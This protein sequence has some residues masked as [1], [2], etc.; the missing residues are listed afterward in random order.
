MFNEQ[1]KAVGIDSFRELFDNKFT[2]RDLKQAGYTLTGE[3]QDAV[4]YGAAVLGPKIGNGFY[5]NM[6][7]RFDQLTVDRWVRRT[8]GRWTGTL[9]DERPDMVAKK[10]KAMRE[11]IIKMSAAEKANF[12]EVGVTIKSRSN[13]DIE[14]TAQKIL[15][16]SMKPANRTVMNRTD[17]GGDLRKAGNGLAKYLDG[18]I[19]SPSD[20]ERDRIRRVFNSGLA[21]LKE[22]YPDLTMADLQALL[23][24]P[25]KLLYDG[26][27][28]QEEFDNG[29]EDAEA[30]DYANAARKLATELGI[31]VGDGDRR[32]AGG[33]RSGRV[34]E[35]AADSQQ[36]TDQEA[37]QEGGL[38][39]PSF[40]RRLSGQTKSYDDAV[41]DGT[42]LN[43]EPN[44]NEL[45]LDDETRIELQLKKW[46]DKYL[47]V[48]KLQ[49]QSKQILGVDELPERLDVHAAETLSHGKIKNDYDG[50]ED[51]YVKPIGDILRE[52][53]ID[54]DD[55][56]LYLIAKHAKERNEYIASKNESLPDGGSGLTTAAAAEIL[57]NAESKDALEE[58]AQLVYDMLEEN[59]Q[60]MSDAG[61]LSE[62]TV[63]GYREQY[64]FYVPLKGF[65]AITVV[66]EDGV[67]QTVRERSPVSSGSTGR[68][69]SITG[70]EVFKALGRES[71]SDN[72]LLYAL[73]D[74]EEKIVRARKN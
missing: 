53:D 34:S 51:N 20:A 70:K 50:L 23:W 57:E 71:M 29:Y 39:R 61:L 36:D 13:S 59:R 60:R 10:T 47:P 33:S 30:P 24:Y 40:Q 67:E 14:E 43:G 9:V 68:G 21:E 25:E 15:K 41:A 58:V 1:I 18:Q 38:E 42:R 35:T 45:N 2:V 55:A 73:R 8:Y 31:E 63:D 66:D 16:A 37:S 44:T 56:A 7:G 52:N 72:P 74:T 54:M 26:A 48:K 64:Q 11:I 65:A 69:F 62:D 22:E 27:R 3:Y 32:D 19:D 28:S 49:Q 17:L 46:Q 12:K 4:V 6:N 5:S